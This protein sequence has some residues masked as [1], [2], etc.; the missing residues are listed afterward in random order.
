[1]EYLTFIQA[2]IVLGTVLG[3]LGFVFNLLL[4]PI[5]KDISHIKEN[6][7][8]HITDT[9]KKI[10]RL[11]TEFKSGQSKLETE[12]KSGQSKLESKLDKLLAKS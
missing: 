2:I 8:N 4:G 12:F 10:D 9:N 6:L 11:E 1:M 3:G 5:K 7:N